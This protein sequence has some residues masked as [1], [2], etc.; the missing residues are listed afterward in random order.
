MDVRLLPGYVPR[1]AILLKVQVLNQLRQT[2]RNLQ[3]VTFFYLKMEIY[4]PFSYM[5][6]VVTNL[7]FRTWTRSPRYFSPYL[8]FTIFF[9]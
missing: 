1:W 2:Y 4:I 6:V 9:I 8:Q 7:L 5:E 3:G